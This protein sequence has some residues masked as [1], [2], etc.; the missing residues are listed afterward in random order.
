[1]AH[2]LN[3]STQSG[4]VGRLGFESRQDSYSFR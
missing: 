2:V 4:S 3:A 1:M